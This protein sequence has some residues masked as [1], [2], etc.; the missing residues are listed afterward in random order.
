M[1]TSQKVKSIGFKSLI[2]FTSY[3]EYSMDYLIVL[4][5]KQPERFK[6]IALDANR[7][8]TEFEMG[9]WG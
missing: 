6:L 4:S 2:E 8:R 9:K 3:T 7:K 5:K 1:K